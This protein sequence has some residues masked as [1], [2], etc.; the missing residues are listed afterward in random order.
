MQWRDGKSEPVEVQ[1]FSSPFYNPQNAT[2]FFQDKTVGDVEIKLVRAES[3]DLEDV[4]IIY[5]LN[6]DEEKG[7][8]LL[9]KEYLEKIAE[10]TCSIF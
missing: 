4:S 9:V 2:A 10:V 7:G 3:T 8:N 6:E 5:T 1:Q